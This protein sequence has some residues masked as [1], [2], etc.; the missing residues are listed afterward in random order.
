MLFMAYVFTPDWL[1]FN[2]S[3]VSGNLGLLL[4]VAAVLTGC[5]AFA[6]LWKTFS[7][8]PTPVADGEL[9]TTGLYA[10]ARH[11]IYTCLL[12]AAFGFAYYSGSGYRML[13]GLA[14]LVLFYF[15]SDYEEKQLIAR[16]PAYSAYRQ[17][18]GRFLPW[19]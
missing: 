9:V 7:P 14:L 13:V 15:K 16:Y 10:L 19:L 3:D 17:K 12:V 18:V 4:A 11:P 5:S 6:L 2:R 1:R 8:F